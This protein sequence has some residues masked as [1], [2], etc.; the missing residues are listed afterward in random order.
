M[1]RTETKRFQGISNNARDAKYNAARD[2][3]KKFGAMMPGVNYALGVVPDEWM[4]W[5]D[6]NL[7]RG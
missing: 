7:E 6:E 5:V 1:S 4:R 2:A 3:T